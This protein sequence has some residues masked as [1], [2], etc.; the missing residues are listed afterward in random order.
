MDLTLQSTMSNSNSLEDREMF[1]L[2]K[3]R[4][5]EIRIIEV[6]VRRFSRDLKV[7]FE[8]AKVRILRVRIRQLTVH[9]VEM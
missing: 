8:L 3:V 7:F 2:Q 5:T 9:L 6:F 4:I 1:E